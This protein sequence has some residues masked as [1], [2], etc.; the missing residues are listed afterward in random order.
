MLLASALKPEQIIRGKWGAALLPSVLLIISTLPIV[1]LCLPLGGVSLYEVLAAYVG[2]LSAITCFSMVSIWCSAK[3]ART[4]SALASAYIFV[5]PAALVGTW[6]WQLMGMATGARLAVFMGFIPFVSAVGCAT[7]FFM[8]VVL[9]RY[10]PDIGS[11]GRDVYDEQQ[12]QRVAV[13]L[14][15][16]RDQ[17]PDR[18]F[19]P[20]KRTDLLPDD[21]NP[22]LDKELRSELFSQGTLMLRL[23]IQAS[24]LLAVP[25]MGACLYFMPRLAPW[26]M[27]YVLFFNML[28]APVFSA[29]AFPPNAS[30]ARLICCSSPP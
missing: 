28:T 12:E 6:M 26:Y 4:T 13:G 1:M 5:L 25:L 18:L 23:V 15:I 27:A 14:I 19:A 7:L 20:A 8:L 29:E 9:L 11:E 3:F 16:Q 17:F 30:V 22:V 10:P 21:V 2:L 24:L